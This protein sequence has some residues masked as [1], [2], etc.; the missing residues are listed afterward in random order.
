MAREAVEIRVIEA[1]LV[2][3]TAFHVGR[4]RSGLVAD[5]EITVDGAAHPY[6]PGTSLAGVL[7]RFL[8]PTKADRLFGCPDANR[9]TGRGA[10]SGTSKPGASFVT[11][12]DAPVVSPRRELRDHVGIDRR[13]G[14]AARNIKLTREVIAAGATLPLRMMVEIAKEDPAAIRDAV[15]ELVAKL[16]AYGLEI[17][18][19]STRGLGRFEVE[20]HSLRHYVLDLSK[21]EDIRTWWTLRARRP[22]GKSLTVPPQLSLGRR[23]NR[24]RFTVHWRPLQ[25]LF[26]KDGVRGAIIDQLPLVTFR[27]RSRDGAMGLCPVLPGSSVKGCLR[28]HAERILRTILGKESAAGG[29]PF[30]AQVQVDGIAGLFGQA[31]SK[32]NER[33]K[34]RLLVRDTYNRNVFARMP[35]EMGAADL[36]KSWPGSAV[37][38]QV[39]IDRWTGGA[40]DSALFT[41]FEPEFARTGFGDAGWEPM[42]FEIDT[43][44]SEAPGSKQALALFWLLLRDLV[45]GRI[46]FG[47]GTGKG[48]GGIEVARVEVDRELPDLDRKS[49]ADPP[50]EWREHLREWNEAWENFLTLKCRKGDHHA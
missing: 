39:S 34:G 23:E 13:T 49:I 8:D 6:V 1:T 5:L 48:Y 11:V 31:R 3:R 43:S 18:S 10:P 44:P 45:E 24:W 28:S 2:A 32:D 19:A 46:P 17:G 47:Y 33:A 50:S 38:T 16:Q 21:L 25:P 14:S 22:V 37:R 30:L 36:E 27:P 40:L 9:Q 26:V 41:T 35:R 4:E 42:V 29:E 20:E 12:A 15:D 7:R